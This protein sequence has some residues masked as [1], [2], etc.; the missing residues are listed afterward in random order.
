MFSKIT[1]IM[2]A[3]LSAQANAYS[4]ELL[5]NLADKAPEPEKVTVN[6]ITYT[7]GDHT[8]DYKLTSATCQP[9]FDYQ[10]YDVK[11]LDT[12]L[13]DTESHEVI[14][15]TSNQASKIEMKLCNTF[16]LEAKKNTGTK[17][18]KGECK[19]AQAFLSGSDGLTC[20]TTFDN[21]VIHSLTEEKKEYNSGYVISYKTKDIT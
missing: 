12:V 17:M 10:L 11:R 21:P 1:A 6:A 8:P 19:S 7:I 15:L 20:E 16:E 4:N 2:G 5:I 13:R 9:V 14:T 18:A 3:F